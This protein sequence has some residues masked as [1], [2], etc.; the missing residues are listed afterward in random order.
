MFEIFIAYLARNR[1]W[2]NLPVIIAI[3]ANCCT[4]RK[5]WYLPSESISFKHRFFFNGENWPILHHKKKKKSSQQH[6]QG[7]VLENFQK[8]CHILRKKRF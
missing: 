2:Q 7:N 8:T 5:H 1:I 4:H 3:L 6:G